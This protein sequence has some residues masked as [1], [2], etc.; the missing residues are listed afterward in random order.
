LET[1]RKNLGDQEEKVRV[2]KSQHMG[3]LPGQLTTNLQILNGLQSQ[4]QGEN[5]ALTAAKQQ[6]AYL[7][8]LLDQYRALQASP[9]SAD[10]APL[11]LPAIDNELEKLR[12]Q[13]A[14]LS[15]RYTEN[16]PDVRKLKEQIAK[17]EKI[18]VQLLAELKAKA[19]AAQS[20]NSGTTA[21]DAFTAAGTPSPMAQ[22]KSQLQANELEISN[23]GHSIASLNAKINEYQARLNQEP[24]REQQLADLTRGYDQS[25]ADYDDLLK[26]KNDSERATDMEKLQQGERF[27]I[28]D[29]PSLPAKPD[30]PNRLKFCGIGL[31]FGLALGAGVVAA[32]EMLDDRLHGEKEIKDMLPIPVLSEIPLIVNSSDEQSAKRKMWLAWGTGAIVFVT[33]LAGSAFSYL[34]G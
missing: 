31:A 1:A 16:H 34:R 12:A 19:S 8:T 15:S 33:I 4:L 27:R 10:G 23:R 14:D 32:F 22:V 3:E 20:D 2:F 26:K 7:Q 28:L 30:F 17:T 9:K 25:K 18:R 29:P 5:D 21:T 6:H 24:I 13:L 11:G